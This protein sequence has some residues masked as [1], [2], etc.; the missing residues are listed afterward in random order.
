[1]IGLHCTKL[2]LYFTYIDHCLEYWREA[3]MCRGDVALATFQWAE[4]KPF[5][6]VWSDHEC[7]DWEHFD[8]WARTRMLDM[9]DYSI[10]ATTMRGRS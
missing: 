1:M 5:S 8:T 9:D 10:L 4:G 7:V 6:R 2:K 3:A